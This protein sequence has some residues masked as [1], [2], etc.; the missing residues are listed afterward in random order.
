ML[1]NKEGQFKFVPLLA[2]IFG[3]AIIVSA[4]ALNI[5]ENSSL[6]LNNSV[7]ENITLNLT[8]PLDNLTAINESVIVNATN[9]TIPIEN[10]TLHISLSEEKIKN[11]SEIAEKNKHKL[12]N[13]TEKYFKN[14]KDKKESGNYIIKF[15]NSIEENKLVNV[16][17]EKRIEQF[18]VTKVKGKAE[19][20]EGLIEDDEIEFIE[21]EQD[22]KILGDNIPFKIGRA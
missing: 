1:R 17:L 22:V 10:N 18:K 9:Q 15:R 12:N 2:I 5:T 3:S 14:L 6:D 19:D 13:E 20:I 4:V 16:T 21:L 8:I 7:F 11:L